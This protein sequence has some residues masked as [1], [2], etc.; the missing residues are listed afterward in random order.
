MTGHGAAE[1]RSGALRVTLRRMRWWDIDAAVAL[2][3]A[4][5]TDDPWPAEGFWSELAGV[6]ATR[7]YLVACSGEEFLG[8][9]GLMVVGSQAD[10]QTLVVA[11]EARGRGVGTTLLRALLDE[12][13]R[14]DAQSVMLEVRADNDQAIRLYE[15][16]GF[17]RLARRHGYYQP[18]GQDA[19]V[20]R[21]LRRHALDDRAGQAR[22]APAVHGAQ[23]ADHD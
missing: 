5:F 22:Q 19:L 13:W 18:S 4:V 17:A 1:T 2:E 9:G 15:R 11:P 10:V 7:Y 12:A 20:M 8:F 23:Q 6:P 14:R 21:L 16:H 3:R